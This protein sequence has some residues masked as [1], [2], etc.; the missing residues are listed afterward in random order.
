MEKGVPVKITCLIENTSIS[1]DLAAEHGLS[2]YIET[3]GKKILFDAGRSGAFADNAKKLGI[4]LSTVDCFVLSHGHY[5]HGEGIRRFLSE[6][7]TASV[8]ARC[9]VDLP[10]Y[11]ASGKYIGLS[12]ET[13]ASLRQCGRL[14]LISNDSFSLFTDSGKEKNSLCLVSGLRGPVRFPMT[15]GFAIGDRRPDPGSRSAPEKTA[16]TADLFSHEMYLLAEEGGRTILFTGCSHRGIENLLTVYHP[17]VLVGGFHCF[18]EKI[19]DQKNSRLDEIADCL[20]ASDTE[21]FT[22]HCTGK[23]QFVYLKEHFKHAKCLHYL[24]AGETVIL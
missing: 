21:F 11:T 9:G 15:R 19:M 7:G 5:D 8:F 2:L 3:C 20:G 1:E 10:F 14:R 22:C 18:E 16:F 13:I 6:N 24:A 23:E 17:D 12:E 4:D